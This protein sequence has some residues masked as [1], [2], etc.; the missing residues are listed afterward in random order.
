M[1]CLFLSIYS[2]LVA[3]KIY[4]K[5]GDKGETGLGGGKRLSKASLRVCAYG[6]VDELT[7]LIGVCRSMNDDLRI[8]NKGEAVFLGEIFTQLQK[9]LWMVAAD[10][11]SPN[12]NKVGGKT[13]PRIGDEDVARLEKWIDKMEARLQPLQSFIVPGGSMLAANLHV[14]RAVCR[15]AER[16]VVRLTNEKAVEGRCGKNEAGNGAGAKVTTVEV[17]APKKMEED[18][19][20][21]K[22]PAEILI[23]INRLSDLLFVAARYANKTAGKVEEKI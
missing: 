4:T 14:A 12:V 6:E 13:V 11:A 16:A 18:A 22:V 5:T 3:M 9:D 15:R 19:L 10:L 7:C 17:V 2:Q 1:F 23:Y 21:N 8:N 20:A